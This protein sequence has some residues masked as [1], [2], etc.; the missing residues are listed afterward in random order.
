MNVQNYCFFCFAKKFNI[1][2]QDIGSFYDGTGDLITDKSEI[3]ELL[4][5]PHHPPI[6]RSLTLILFYS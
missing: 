2:K 5:Q 6:K 1:T 3:S 4:E